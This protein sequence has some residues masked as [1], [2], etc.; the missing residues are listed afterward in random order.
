[1]TTTDFRTSWEAAQYAADQGKTAATAN[2]Q[3][4]LARHINTCAA[5]D[6]EI[7]G[8]TALPDPRPWTWPVTRGTSEERRARVD[9]WA[10]RHGVTAGPDLVSGTYRA[11]LK[12]GPVTLTVYTMGEGNLEERMAEIQRLA[13]ETLAVTQP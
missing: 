3:Q 5:E 2:G 1:M 4:L 7:L 6:M 9:A 11:T 13:D 8:L 10:A 12:F